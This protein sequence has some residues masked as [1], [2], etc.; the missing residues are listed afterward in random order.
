MAT[1]EQ[2][3]LDIPELARVLKG[4]D[5]TAFLVPARV[6]R[7][8]IKLDRNIGGMGLNVPHRKSYVIGRAALLKIAERH[9]LGLSPHEPLPSKLIL[10]A[11]PDPDALARRTAEETLVKYWRMLFHARLDLVMEQKLAEGTLNRESVRQRIQHL[12]VTEF[13]EI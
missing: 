11:Q 3:T 8:V 10:L 13:D 5:P 4:V 6:L 9:E 7:R 2:V 12:G 1:T